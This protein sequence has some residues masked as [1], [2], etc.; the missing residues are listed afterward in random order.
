VKTKAY[1]AL[2]A[3]CFFWG[4]TY[5]AIR[6]GVQTIPIFIFSGFRFVCAGLIMCLYFILRGHRLPDLKDFRSLMVSGILLFVG[7]NLILCYAEIEIPS[8]L[9]ALICA[10]FP[11]WIVLINYILDR[12]DKPSRKVMIGLLLGFA[13][14]VIIFRDNLHHLADPVYLVSII[15]LISANIFWAI[16]SVYSKRNPVKINLLFGAGIQMLCCG[17]VSAAVGIF[18]GELTHLVLTQDGIF[19]FVYLV[20]AGSIIGYN[21]F[22]YSLQELPSTLVSI[23]AYVNPVIAILLGWVVLDENITISML[24]AMIITLAGVYIVNR[25]MQEEKK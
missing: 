18:K 10:A 23:Y 14:L 20:V 6:V 11:F 16:G 13:G 19:S 8:G 21:C 3:L 2:A 1:I 17:T 7:G 24:I 12:N 5:L 15:L 25:G 9:A 22:V 4:T